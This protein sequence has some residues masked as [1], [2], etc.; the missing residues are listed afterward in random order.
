MAMSV[1]EHE[2]T[3][4]LKNADEPLMAG[5]RNNPLKGL[6]QRVTRNRYR[7]QTKIGISDCNS[8]E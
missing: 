4:S 8:I 7:Q 3:L 6:Q 5:L 1:N 2:K